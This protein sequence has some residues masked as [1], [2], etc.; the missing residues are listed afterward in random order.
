MRARVVLLVI[1]AA[2]VACFSQSS[3]GPGTGPA[4]DASADVG[5]FDSSMP[6]AE[7]PMEAAPHDG[8]ADSTTPP[9]EGGPMEGG[10]A[11][12]GS[13]EAGPT[14]AEPQVDAVVDAG[15]APV[16]VVVGGANGYESGISVVFSDVSGNV[17]A[18]PTTDGS[19]QASYVV[20]TGGMVTIVLGTIHAPLLTTYVGVAPGQQILMADPTTLPELMPVAV[21]GLPAEPVDASYSYY[22]ALAGTCA[23]LETNTIPIDFN[24]IASPSCIGFA[25]VGTS[26]VGAFPLLVDALD[27]AGHLQGYLYSSNN[28]LV[29]TNDLGQL[30]PTV[31]ATW[32]TDQLGQSVSVTGATGTPLITYSEVGDG[33]LVPSLSRTATTP[34]ATHPSFASQ[35]Q[36]E[37]FYGGFHGQ[38]GLS[39]TIVSTSAAAPT[40]SGTFTLD[41]SRVSAEPAIGIPGGSAVPGGLAIAWSGDLGASTGVVAVA[42]WN[43]NTDAGTQYGSWTIVSP[44]TSSTSLQTPTLPPG[45]SAYAPQVAGPIGSVT[46]YGVDGQTAFPTYASLLPM[47]PL[48]VNQDVSCDE[49]TPFT[50]IL[51]TGGTVLLSMAANTPNGC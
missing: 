8:S 34:Y 4:F 5:G 25:P 9:V 15:P 46:V 48:F 16:V 7:E 3:S 20:P 36:V 21:G 49:V 22:Q 30:A 23:S 33:V 35:V 27:S 42:S 51:P 1:P 13:M 31:P 32:S 29:A 50:P 45:V 44:G 39:G 26:Y 19:G 17:L 41:G 24:L 18:S 43:G 14:D 10:P 47:A 2:W 38:L 37:A 11:E 40:T 28:S 12:A 6:D